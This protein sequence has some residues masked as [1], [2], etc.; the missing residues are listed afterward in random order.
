[1]SSSFSSSE[2]ALRI[3]DALKH[4]YPRPK[5][6]LRFSDPLQLLVATIL[7][8]QCTDERVNK[9]TEDLFKKYRTCEDYVKA[10]LDELE[11]DI[12]PTGFYKN[13][14]RYLKKACQV[15]IERFHSRVPDNMQDLLSLPGVARKTA[16]IVL[17]NAFGKNEGIA[18]DTH[19]RRLS[20]KL[21]LT[22]EEDPDKIESDLMALIPKHDWRN[23]TLL[24]ME[25]GR[26]ICKAKN[27]LCGKCSLNHICPSAFKM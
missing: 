18:V 25:H 22:E 4:E 19:V 23:I 6:A 21:G 13:K 2:R 3:L 8:A 5:I 27:P 15:L 14:A 26:K 10:P 20:R 17:S 16:N 7:S 24:L 11:R 1:M 9:V 12:K